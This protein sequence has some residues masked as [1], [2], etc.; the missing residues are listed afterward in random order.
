[1]PLSIFSIVEREYENISFTAA[2]AQ[3][4]EW[5]IL[6]LAIGAVLASLL[7]LYHQSVPGSLVRALL[8]AEAH[9]PEKALTL[10]DLGLDRALIRL[11][12]HRGAVTKKFVLA[13]EAAD[14]EGESRYYIPEELRYRAA[15]RYEKKGN[16]PISVL[17]TAA[18]AL[19]MAFLL[20]RLIPLALGMIDSML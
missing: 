19:A 4:L 10:A 8:R 16:G 18:L 12:L 15:V 6:A 9:S 7:M 11:E 14:G 20:T 2:D 13:T 3:L 5:I 17:L 1:M